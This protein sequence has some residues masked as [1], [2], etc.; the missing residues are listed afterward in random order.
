MVEEGRKT[1]KLRKKKRGGIQY[2]PIPLTYITIPL[3]YITIPL[4][5]ITIPSQYIHTP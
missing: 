2:I 3:T 4:Y 1:K 5:T